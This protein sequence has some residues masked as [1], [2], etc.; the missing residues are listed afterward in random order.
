MLL[1]NILDGNELVNSTCP[2]FNSSYCSPILINQ[3]VNSNDKVQSQIR[4][5]NEINNTWDILIHDVTADWSFE[6]SLTYKPDT[7]NFEVIEERPPFC[8]VNCYTLPVLS[9]L[10]PFGHVVFGSDFTGIPD[11]LSAQLYGEISSNNIGEDHANA[12]YD[13]L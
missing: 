3:T 13:L 10:A 12:K 2:D 1:H 7:Y 8:I 9:S 5:I 6:K 4:L 11:T